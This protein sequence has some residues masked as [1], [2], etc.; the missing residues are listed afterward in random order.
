MLT[1]ERIYAQC[2]G[3]MA[4]FEIVR[5]KGIN[6]YK[7]AT[8]THT[9]SYTLFLQYNYTQQLNTSNCI[10]EVCIVLE[11]HAAIAACSSRTM[12]ISNIQFTTTIEKCI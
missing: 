6:F 2:Q 7:K 9:Y 1:L 10:F 5:I 3:K 12:H 11:L 8:S 4:C